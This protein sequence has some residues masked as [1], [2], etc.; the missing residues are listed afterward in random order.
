LVAGLFPLLAGLF[1]LVADVGLGTVEA[2]VP[3]PPATTAAAALASVVV[4]VGTPVGRSCRRTALAARPVVTLAGVAVSPLRSVGVLGRT[5]AGRA[6]VPRAGFGRSG[7]SLRSAHGEQGG[8]ALAVGGV[9]VAG[10]FVGPGLGPGAP[11]H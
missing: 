2:P 8:A 9:A 3:A 5:V 7:R 6:L 10:P 11:P 4:D 1:P